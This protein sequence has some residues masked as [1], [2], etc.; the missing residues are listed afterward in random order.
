MMEMNVP[1]GTMKMSPQGRLEWLLDTLDNNQAGGWI[2]VPN[3]RQVPLASNAE[4]VVGSGP[5]N[6][7][8]YISKGYLPR[9]PKK[10]HT[11]IESWKAMNSYFFLLYLRKCAH[12]CNMGFASIASCGILW[13]IMTAVYF[14]HSM[15]YF[16]CIFV[17]NRSICPNQGRFALIVSLPLACPERSC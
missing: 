12:T 16:T 3:V 11:S 2:H 14:F 8:G 4:M 17:G 6:R 10:I 7:L 13:S 15:S 1:E 9:I 5:H